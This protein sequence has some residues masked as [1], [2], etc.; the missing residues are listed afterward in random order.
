M[1]SST[2]TPSSTPRK[3]RVPQLTAAQ[4]KAS[5]TQNLPAFTAYETARLALKK[6]GV[7]AKVQKQLRAQM[8]ANHAGFTVYWRG[9][10]DPRQVAARAAARAKKQA[11]AA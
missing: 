7:T 6:D 4:L 10:N 1:A 5:L 11:A 2:H 9:F 3:T 8:D